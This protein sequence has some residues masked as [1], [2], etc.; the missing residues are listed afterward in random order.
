[1]R[2]ITHTATFRP[3]DSVERILEDLACPACG[4]RDPGATIPSIMGDRVRFFC[5]CCGAF[6]T[7]VLT[8]E[9]AAALDI[10]RSPATRGPWSRTDTEV[11]APA[12]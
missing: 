11:S 5:D 6:T 12:R 2:T 3:E 4:Y 1:M 7:T 9:Q 10:A 8:A